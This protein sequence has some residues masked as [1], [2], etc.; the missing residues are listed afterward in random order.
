[1]EYLL[2]QFDAITY[3]DADIFFFSDPKV[4]Y[5]EIGNKSIGIVPHRFSERERIRLGNNGTFNVGVVYAANTPSGRT[6]IGRWAEQ[7]REWCFARNDNGKFGDQAYLDSWPQDYPGE[8]CIIKNLGVNLGPWSIG[9]YGIFQSG[10]FVDGIYRSNAG[11][12]CI[13]IPSSTFSDELVCYH[14]HE[15]IH[16][17]RCTDYPLRLR[18][19][20][21]IYEPYIQAV[22]EAGRKADLADKAIRERK[23]EMVERGA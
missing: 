10:K 7:C 13:G 11:P 19:R 23:S 17:L 9:N 18:D 5:E 14:F 3:L 2:P 6:C 8:V 15:Y 21:L 12:I 1:M 22:G 4:I 20:E 16:N